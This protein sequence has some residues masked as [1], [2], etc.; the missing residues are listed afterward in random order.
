MQVHTVNIGQINKLVR[1][2]KQYQSKQ[3][4]I[5]NKKTD[6]PRFLAA[7]RKVQYRHNHGTSWQTNYVQQ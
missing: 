1:H 3:P 6:L 4:N 5:Q 2:G 7:D